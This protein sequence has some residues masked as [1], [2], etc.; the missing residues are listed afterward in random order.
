MHAASSTDNDGRIWHAPTVDV[1][2]IHPTAR[3]AE[4]SSRGRQRQ[5]WVHQHE[6]RVTSRNHCSSAD[7]TQLIW[8]KLLSSEQSAA[9]A[10]NTGLTAAA[11]LTLALLASSLLK[12]IF[13]RPKLTLSGVFVC[14]FVVVLFFVG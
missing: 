9:G 5:N 1:D 13:Q 6:S 8:L 11:T 12:K 4:L 14:C 10:Q 3:G 7:E 2:C